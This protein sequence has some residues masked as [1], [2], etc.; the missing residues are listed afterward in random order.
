MHLTNI[1]TGL[2][3]L[4]F[5]HLLEFCGVT[6]LRHN[7][8]DACDII[9]ETLRPTAVIRSILPFRDLAPQSEQL[10]QIDE[11][12]QASSRRHFAK[13]ILRPNAC[14]ARGYRG[15][16]AALIIKVDPIFA[17]VVPICDQRKFAAHQRMERVRQHERSLAIRPIN[18]SLVYLCSK[19]ENGDCSTRGRAVA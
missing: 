7:L 6:N 4:R 3:F 2:G 12:Q 1:S 11:P 14:P 8:V 5:P 13:R 16:V 18:L 10:Q 9:S 15:Q 19:G 17:P